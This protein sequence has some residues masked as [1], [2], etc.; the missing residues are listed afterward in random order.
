MQQTTS[1]DTGDL[2]ATLDFSK[3]GAPATRQVYVARPDATAEG[4]LRVVEP[5]FEADEAKA[6]RAPHEK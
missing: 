6:Y 2:V 1:A 4:G 5:L 3:P